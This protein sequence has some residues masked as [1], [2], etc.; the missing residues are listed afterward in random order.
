MSETTFTRKI[1]IYIDSG[2]ADAAQKTLIANQDKLMAKLDAQ[3]QKYKDA[4]DNYVANPSTKAADAVKKLGNEMDATKASIEK[5]TT[6]LDRANKKVNGEL[7]P[8]LKDLSST[9]SKLSRELNVM[10][11]EDPLRSLKATQLAEAQEGLLKLK[12]NAAAVKSGLGEML[13]GAGGIA[14]GVLVGNWATAVSQ[15][16]TSGFATVAKMRTD[17]ENSSRTLSAIT[18]ADGAALE[19]L[20]VTAVRLST[21]STKSAKDFLEAMKLIASAKPELLKDKE[22]L[23]QV[24][25]EALRLSKA[26]GMDL[27]EAATKLTDALNQYGEPA[28]AAAK[29]VDILAASAKYGAAEIPG[30]TEAL[31]EFGPIAKQSNVAFNESSA[32]IELFAEKGLKGAEAGTK[33]RNILLTLSAAKSLPAE[34]LKQL[35]AYGVNIDILSDKHLSLEQRLTE[36]SK[37][38]GDANAMMAVFDKQNVVAGSIILQNIPRYAQLAEQVKEVGVANAQASTNTATLTSLWGKFT[39]VMSAFVLGFPLQGLKSFVS[40]LI[41]GATYV[42][43]MTGAIQSQSQ[44]MEQERIALN[45][46]LI[47]ITSSN[48][49]TQ[50]RKDLIDKLNNQ[51]PTFLENM[52]KETVTNE[53][54]RDRLKEVNEQYV[55]KIILQRKQEEIET[56]AEKLADARMARMK[57]EESLAKEIL[58]YTEKYNLQ[59]KDGTLQDK[60]KELGKLLLDI[61]RNQEGGLGIAFSAA[62]RGVTAMAG[63]TQNLKITTNEEDRAAKAFEEL[64]KK[65]EDLAKLLGVGES[66]SSVTN[67]ITEDTGGGESDAAKAAREKASKEKIDGAQ[68]VLAEIEKLREESFQASLSGNDK[69]IEAVRVKY[70]KIKEEARKFGIDISLLERLEAKEIKGIESEADLKDA[71]VKYTTR[72][73]LVDAYYAEE[74]TK[75]RQA[76]ADEQLTKEEYEREIALL[77]VQHKNAKADVAREMQSDSSKA[78]EQFVDLNKAANDADLEYYIATQEK[79][80]AATA[81]F[82]QHLDTEQQKIAQK[83]AEG[84]KSVVSTW[85]N[86]ATQ[87]AG[88]IGQI[89][90]NL[91]NAELAREKKANDKRVKSYDDMLN[92]KKISQKAHDKLVEKSAKELAD[93]EHEIKVKQFKREQAIKIVETIITTAAAAIQ[94]YNS[95]AGIPI[96]GVGLGAAAAAVVAAFGAVQ[97]GIIASQEPPSYGGGDE[98]WRMGIGGD[99][100]SDASGGNPI[101]DPNTGATL[102]KVEKGEAFIPV[103]ST[104]ANQAPIKWMLNNRG[105][106]LPNFNVSRSIDNVQLFAQGSSS[107]SS[108]GGA[109]SSY[110][111]IST[112]E[113]NSYEMIKEMREMTAAVKNIKLVFSKYDYDTFNERNDFVYQR[114]SIG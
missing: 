69:E 4:Y 20:E 84:V 8:S 74:K 48:E 55:N 13:K 75:I 3:K 99:K 26:S 9:V 79:K 1:N 45:S 30:I 80:K 106:P 85:I 16:I 109:G 108:S 110:T 28:S 96:I 34:A 60:A 50:R 104:E 72:L 90:N 32:A 49:G 24:T 83:Q 77:D 78:A 31:V 66:P 41:D 82:I 36:L 33:M 23:A 54:L 62:E 27:P 39:N 10:S 71:N 105:K 86:T 52:D 70:A 81:G 29:Y 103:D 25:E 51:Y 46:L 11:L 65:K 47:Q 35:E 38:Q 40:L 56:A 91:D 63:Y 102:G 97:V 21:T 92:H 37:I 6:A 53:Q 58:F 14:F 17:F 98:A 7:S 88:G 76:L 15:G 87:I 42:A 59:L 2:Q 89:L 107:Y 113:S 64:V 67:A 93:K 5:N 57:Q 44:S 73:A 100:H 101:I 112:T 114:G 12:N 61:N 95:L 111:N 43:K 18:G 19:Y 22:G 68:K 94:A